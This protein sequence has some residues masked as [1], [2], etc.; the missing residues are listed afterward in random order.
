MRSPGPM[1]TPG[2]STSARPSKSR[3]TVRSQPAFSAGYWPSSGPASGE[4]VKR[5]EDSSTGAAGQGSRALME[6]MY[7]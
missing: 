3:S 6:E 5:G 7:R 4:H 2:R 1:T